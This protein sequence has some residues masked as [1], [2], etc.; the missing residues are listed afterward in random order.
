[1]LSP[2]FV[3]SSRSLRFTF[4]GFKLHSWWSL[5]EGSCHHTKP[6]DTK[7]PYKLWENKN[8]KLFKMVYLTCSNWFSKCILYQ[9]GCLF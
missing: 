1:L 5:L 3:R 2:N 7:K 6:T 9:F 8:K 4:S